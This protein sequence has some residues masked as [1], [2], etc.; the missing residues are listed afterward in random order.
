MKWSMAARDSG[1]VVNNSE[2]RLETKKGLSEYL[3]NLFL[4]EF[5]TISFYDDFCAIFF[6]V[7]ELQSYVFFFFFRKAFKIL[8][9]TTLS[10]FYVLLQIFQILIKINKGYC[11]DKNFS[12]CFAS[13]ESGIFFTRFSQ[14]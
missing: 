10:T 9:S 6:Y 2:R 13:G 4:C 5:T 12:A 11:C 8:L 14:V 3:M 7:Y 1:G